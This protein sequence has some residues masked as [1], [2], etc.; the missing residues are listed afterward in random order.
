MAKFFR[1]PFADNGLKISV[2]D[3]ST[4]DGSVSYEE[5]FTIDYSLN[6][7]IDPNAKDV[8]LEQTNELF[9]DATEALRQYQTQGFYE[10]ITPA[11]NGGIPFPYDKASV[12][13][14]DDGGGFKNYESLFDGNVELPSNA[15]FWAILEPIPPADLGVTEKQLQDGDFIFTE[16]VG[17]ADAYILNPSPAY[18]SY[19]KGQRIDFIAAN[20]NTG[21]STV[22]ISS[23]GV[24]A[25]K[26]DVQSGTI[27]VKA[28]EII[29]GGVYRLVYDGSEFHLLNP[30]AL[31]PEPLVT[32]QE[33]QNGTYIFGEDTGVADAYVVENVSPF[34]SY[35]KG[36]RFEFIAAN[37]N[38]GASTLNISSLGPI[39][40]KV[41]SP[42][43]ISDLKPNMIV[44]GGVY[45]VVYDG[46]IF[47]LENPSTTEI[48]YV[49]VSLNAVQTITGDSSLNLIAYDTVTSDLNSWFNIGTSRITPTIN[50]RYGISIVQFFTNFTGGGVT[51][52]N[53]YVDVNL[54]ASAYCRFSQYQNEGPG[55]VTLPGHI[56][57]Q[58]NGTTDYIE[59]ISSLNAVGQ[60]IDMTGGPVASKLI[61]TYLGA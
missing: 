55:D 46:L 7:A 5:G 4:I 31:T 20:T 42:L 40:I 33:L 56:E 25:I 9:F 6:Q 60:S 1:F 26:V 18:L 61:L 47:Q 54:N 16:D 32:V 24:S 10:F 51:D 29:F 43:S 57:V 14:Y 11:Q 50:G 28:G 17:L 39:A 48:F 44:V 34:V 21:P 59:I 37:T 53:I 22:N 13:R 27:D 12:T 41:T 58:M 3:D 19:E 30:S 23:N 52:Y 35:E 15:S 45:R 38:T 49:N 8:P 2:P 36:Q